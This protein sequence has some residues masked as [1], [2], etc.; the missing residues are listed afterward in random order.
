M[1]PMLLGVLS[2]DT[3]HPPGAAE[4]DIAALA[5]QHAE[6]V[7]AGQLVGDGK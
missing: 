5:R 6:T 1:G 3:P 4:I 7:L 2:R